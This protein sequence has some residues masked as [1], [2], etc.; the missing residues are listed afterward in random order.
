MFNMIPQ[1]ATDADVQLAEQAV[2]A[3]RVEIANKNAD[4]HRT[5]ELVKTVTTTLNALKTHV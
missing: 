3:C 1:L 2:N 4:I 5:E